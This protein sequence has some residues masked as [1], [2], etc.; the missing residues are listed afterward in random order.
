MKTFSKSYTIKSPVAKVW[1]AF[2]DPKVIE[3]WGGGTVKMKLEK[4]F[5]GDTFGMLSDQFGVDW[6]MNI[7]SGNK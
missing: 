2:A 4:Q 3:L 1:Q 6:N 7:G 5:W